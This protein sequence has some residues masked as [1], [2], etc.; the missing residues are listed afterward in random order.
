MGEVGKVILFLLLLVVF[1]TTA[2]FVVLGPP[3]IIKH[4]WTYQ[5]FDDGYLTEHSRTCKKCPA[6]QYS[7]SHRWHDGKDVELMPEKK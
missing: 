6:L 7:I 4:D 1:S 3:C 5:A 2:T